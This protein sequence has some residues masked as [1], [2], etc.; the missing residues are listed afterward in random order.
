MATNTS[1]NSS[2]SASASLGASSEKGDDG[3]KTTSQNGGFNLG[4]EMGSSASSDGVSINSGG[5]LTIKGK[6]VVNQEA[7]LKSQDGTRI[8]GQ[9]ENQKAANHDVQ[10]GFDVGASASSEKKS[11]GN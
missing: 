3:S 2:I 4:G 9:V 10:A 11:G 7:E 6:T 8:D 5:A 1:S